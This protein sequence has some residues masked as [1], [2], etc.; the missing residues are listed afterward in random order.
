MAETRVNKIFIIA[1][2]RGT[3]KTSFIKKII[4][5]I[6]NNYS[7]ILIADTYPNPDWKS[8][9]AFDYPEGAN[10]KIQSIT[11][12]QLPYWTKGIKFLYDSDTDKMQQFI[13]KYVD[14]SAVFLEDSTKFIGKSLSKSMRV[15]SLDTKQKNV[16]LY[17][18]FHNTAS[19]PLELL[20]IA[21]LLYLKKTGESLDYIKKRLAQVPNEHD[22]IDKLFHNPDRFAVELIKLN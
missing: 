9:K 6:Q 10:K 16:D 5:I 2:T 15:F 7:K 8:L 20:R 11:V 14:N 22:K 17:Y 4:R 1:G 3:G 12:N 19:I 13:E 18:I 21:D